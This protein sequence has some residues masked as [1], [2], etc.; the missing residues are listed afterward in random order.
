MSV[1]GIESTRSSRTG[2]PHVHVVAAALQRDGKYLLGQ[3]PA[4]SNMAGYWEFPGG[5]VREGEPREIALAREL[6]EELAIEVTVGSHLASVDHVYPHLE[7]S[8]HLYACTLRKGEPRA[9][10]HSD[11]EWLGRDS[12][13]SIGLAPSN[14]GFVDVL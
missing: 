14:R 5:K 3:R 10:F 1:S 6:A 8:L 2:I 11:I 9:L 12:M 4:G 7:I 13:G